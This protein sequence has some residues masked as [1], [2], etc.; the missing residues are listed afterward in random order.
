[1]IWKNISKAF[2][3]LL[4]TISLISCGSKDE[5][6]DDFST[7]SLDNYV[8][9][10]GETK[11]EAKIHQLSNAINTNTIS[12]TEID[13][14]W[15]YKT[16]VLLFNSDCFL[17]ISELGAFLTKIQLNSFEFESTKHYCTGTSLYSYNKEYEM[18]T[19]HVA[20]DRSSINITDESSHYAFFYISD[21]QEYKVTSKSSNET[22]SLYV[23]R[24]SI[25]VSLESV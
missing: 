8:I 2:P 19:V 5:P 13:L 16:V 22:C 6:K 1:M 14:T 21:L 17:S 25:L 3:L 11:K 15:E 9:E 7:Q 4:C 24:G 12:K 20:A 18:D 10:E 23:T